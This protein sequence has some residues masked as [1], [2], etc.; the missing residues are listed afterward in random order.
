MA[1]IKQIL[2]SCPWKNEQ[3]H[4]SDG[5]FTCP[6][7]Y[8]A[9]LKLALFTLWRPLGFGDFQ[10][11]KRLNARGFAR[12]FLG[13]VC[14]KDP[15]KVSKDVTSL[16]ICIRKKRLGLEPSFQWKFHRKTLW[17]SGWALGQA[18]WAE[19]TLKLFHLWH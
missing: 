11:K 1:S 5:P 10:K 15:V 18:I 12:E 16:L 4:N 13:L 17:P 8:F 9:W 2:H 19:M 7:I 3:Y 6:K 14:S